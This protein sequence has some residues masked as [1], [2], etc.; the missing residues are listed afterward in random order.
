MNLRPH[1]Q[2]ALDWAVRC[3]GHDHVYN[4]RVRA[5]RLAEES[6]ELSQSLDVSRET[7][8]LLIDAVYDRPR[9]AVDQEMGG[10]ALTFTVLAASF[11]KDPD[12]YLITELRR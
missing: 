5:L 11:D 7:M 9:G 6:V 10:V 2:I 1:I 3:F 12:E 4:A 8:H